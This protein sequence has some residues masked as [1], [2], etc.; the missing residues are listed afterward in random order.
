MMVRLGQSIPKAAA[1]VGCSCCLQW[2]VFMKCS[3]RKQQDHGW[4]GLMLGA[5]S[6]PKDELL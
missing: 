5:K 3:P 4:P 1:L 2:L 6:R